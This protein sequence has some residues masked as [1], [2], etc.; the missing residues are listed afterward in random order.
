MYTFLF[1]V[2]RVIS[3]RLVT[4]EIIQDKMKIDL[5]CNWV[6]GYWDV[7]NSSMVSSSCYKSLNLTAIDLKKSMSI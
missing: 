4:C 1:R 5:I 7:N 3:E 2:L 6:F